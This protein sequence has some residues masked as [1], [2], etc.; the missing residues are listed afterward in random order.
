MQNKKIRILD[1]DGSVTA[2][3][4]VLG[5][6]PHEIV[7]LR[8]IGPRVRFW[9]S[10]DDE[11]LMRGRIAGRDSPAVTLFGSG[12]FH[13]LSC[14]LLKGYDK[15]LTV[16]NFDFHPDWSLVG[17]A[18]NCGSWVKETLRRYG[19]VLK[20]ILV[21]VSSDDLSVR[22]IITGDLAALK[23][24]RLEIYPYS[25]YPTKVPLRRV[26][27]NISINTKRGP[28]MTT[29]FWNDLKGKNVK[30]LF[31]HILNRLPSKNVYISIDKDCLKK[32]HALTN[33]EEGRMGLDDL[34]SIIRL[35]RERCDLAGAD[36]TGEYSPIRI[37]GAIKRAV[38]FLDH[39]KDFSARGAPGD[40]VNSVN[41]ETNLRI[42][43]CL[44]G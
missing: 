22:S 18:L 29:V 4:K 14:L 34:L 24:D 41:E 43:K 11:K 31:L 38:S 28:F 37:N 25:H 2:Q 5:E 6:Y 20:F 23:Y 36:I 8:D 3:K 44:I 19:N 27:D 33:W 7:D 32:E 9:I 1:L 21:G 35:V 16:I 17:P 30:E 10:P 39:P 26:P 12:D 42:L 15:P 13:H 40:R